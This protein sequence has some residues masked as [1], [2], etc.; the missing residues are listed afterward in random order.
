MRTAVWRLVVAEIAIVV[1][2]LA[3]FSGSPIGLGVA[4]VGALVGRRRRLRPARRSMVDRAVPGPPPLASQ[5]R[6][7][8]RAATPFHQRVRRPRHQRRHRLR[9]GRLVRG[10]RDRATARRLRHPRRA[11][12]GGPA[13]RPARRRH[14]AAQRPPG[15]QLGR[16]GA[17]PP[18]AQPGAQRRLLPAT[19]RRPAAVRPGADRPARLGRGPARRDRRGRRRAPARRRRRGRAPRGGRRR[20]PGEQGA[21]Q[22]RHRDRDPRPAA[23]RRGRAALRRRRGA[24]GA[25]AEDWTTFHAGGLHHLAFEVQGLPPR[26]APLSTLLRVRRPPRWCSRVDLRPRGS[27]PAGRRPVLARTVVRMAAPAPSLPEAARTLSGRAGQ[28]GLKLRRLDGWQGPA[29]YASAPTGGGPW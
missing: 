16:A 17:T 8:R 1:V 2:A 29:A 14:P 21:G 25:P 20:R 11:G 13:G 23:A 28:L 12:P 26:E 4:A 7:R 10:R 15:G 9:R 22:R 6:R 18:A 3:A 24:T 19:R 5:A 27:G